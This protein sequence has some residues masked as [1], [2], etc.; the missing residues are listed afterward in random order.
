MAKIVPNESAPADLTTVSLANEVLDFSSGA[1]EAE[2][3]A[4]LG[5]AEVHPW[6]AVE[7]PEVEAED[8][9]AVRVE[10]VRYEDDALSA[11][12]SVAFDPEE[13]AKVEDAK[14]EVRRTPTAIEAGLD[15]NEPV[16]EANVA[17]T[18]AADDQREGGDES[19]DA[20][21]QTDP[22]AFGTYKEIEA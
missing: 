16:V 2:D 3:R 5:A 17:Y 19:E 4:V 10:S 9:D 12:N 18:I 1:V 7:Y 21:A 6:L 15:Q 20:P 22:A 8:A 14:R 13:I 11:V